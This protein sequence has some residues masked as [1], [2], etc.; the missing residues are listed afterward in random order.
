MATRDPHLVL[1]VDPNASQATIKAAWRRLAREHHPDLT[2][3][4]AAAARRSTRRMAEINAAYQTLRDGGGGAAGRSRAGRS[5]GGTGSAPA[6]G[7]Q[8]RPAGPPPPPRTRP[9]TGRLDTTDTMRPRNATTGRPARPRGQAPLPPRRADREPP[10]AS[11]PNGPIESRGTFYAQRFK[12]FLETSPELYGKVESVDQNDA[13]R[14]NV[15]I[16]K[17]GGWGFSSFNRLDDIRQNIQKAKSKLRDI[18]Y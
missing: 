7:H 17:N 15:R 4:D 5:T 13:D 2:A 1:G 14:G 9:V 6:S 8:R 3:G 18:W 11:D 10:R 16:L 12:A